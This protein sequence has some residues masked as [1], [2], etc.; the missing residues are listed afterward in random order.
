M[1]KRPRAI[2]FDRDE[3]LYVAD[4][5]HNRVV[6]FKQDGAC[7]T[8][9]GDRKEEGKGSS[10]QVAAVDIA[11]PH[12]GYRVYEDDG[13]IYGMHAGVSRCLWIRLWLCSEATLQQT[14]EHLNM[15]KVPPLLYAICVNTVV[16]Y[17]VL[18]YSAARGRRLW[19]RCT[20][21]IPRLAAV[22]VCGVTLLMCSL[23]GL[24]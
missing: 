24:S 4:S 20:G 23:M 8:T 22:C 15:H 9:F 2:A 14:H 12:V 17:T 7:I 5:A 3:N 18:H 16:L 19:S 10:A 21:Q 13:D 1:L 11:F 6:V